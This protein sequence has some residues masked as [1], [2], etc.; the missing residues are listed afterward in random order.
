MKL[1]KKHLRK[2]YTMAKCSVYECGTK[3][4]AR[5]F[6]GKHYTRFM[7]HEDVNI[8]YKERKDRLM[9]NDS[10]SYLPSKITNYECVAL[11]EIFYNRK[12]QGGL[13]INYNEALG[14]D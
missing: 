6:C 8:N 10:S 11:K 9:I 2:N 12:F 13:K 5:G 4:R 1:E 14:I 7:R 3:I